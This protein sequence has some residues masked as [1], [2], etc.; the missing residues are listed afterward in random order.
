MAAL[1]L[2]AVVLS[3]WCLQKRIDATRHDVI[4]RRLSSA[5]EV[6]MRPAHDVLA[7]GA[8]S[9]AFLE[10]L[11]DV[12]S[13]T[14]LR[15]TLIARDGTALADSEVRGPMP[16][17]SDRPE[18]A[19]ALLTEEEASA[20]R[21]S[22]LT[23]KETVYVARAVMANGVVLGTIRAATERSEIDDVASGMETVLVVLA[24]MSIALGAVLG[25]AAVRGPTV[26]VKTF[27][28]GHASEQRRERDAA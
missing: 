2:A 12:G 11:R 17:L 13:L 27:D 19:Q 4:Q 1:L 18:V 23:G 26:R 6:L 21:T 8:S 9:E 7:S 16:N 10:R 25:A 15:I 5:A 28:L 20:S 22:V 24:A 14:G 3:F